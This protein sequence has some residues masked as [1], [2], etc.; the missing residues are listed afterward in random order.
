MANLRVGLRAGTV[1]NEDGWGG[2]LQK[3]GGA[4]IANK[5]MGQGEGSIQSSIHIL[6]RG[7][8]GPITISSRREGEITGELSIFKIIL[9]ATAFSDLC[10]LSSLYLCNY[11]SL[12]SAFWCH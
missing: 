11:R 5:Y 7:A 3:V 2:L 4:G 6:N 1:R 12:R 9:V 10:S 8:I